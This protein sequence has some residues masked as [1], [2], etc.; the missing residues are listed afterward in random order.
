MNEQQE[1][2]IENKE[3]PAS[4]FI[5]FDEDGFAVYRLNFDL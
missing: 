4:E 1:Q 2:P 5:G 3:E